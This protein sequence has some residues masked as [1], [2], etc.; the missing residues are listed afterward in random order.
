MSLSL[1]TSDFIQQ[2][3]SIFSQFW[4]I[5]ALV[6]GLILLPAI[7]ETAKYAFDKPYQMKKRP[8]HYYRE[9]AYGRLELHLRRR[10]QSVMWYARRL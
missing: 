5:I 8:N 4:P 6:S 3:G 2:I 1:S 9:N 10:K 7:I